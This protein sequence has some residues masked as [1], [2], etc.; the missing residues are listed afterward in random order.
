[1]RRKIEKT[2]ANPR[3]ESTGIQSKY[4]VKRRGLKRYL[5]LENRLLKKSMSG[6]GEDEA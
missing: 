3:Q 6:D 4:S 1:M 2:S 5:T